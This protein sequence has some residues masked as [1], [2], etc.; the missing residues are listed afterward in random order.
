MT[1]RLS[2]RV[3]LTGVLLAL[4]FVMVA[5]EER[6]I[7]QILSEPNRYARR[8][9]GLRGTVVQSYSI[10]GRGAYQIE[11]GTGKLWV[12]S[13]RGVPRKGSRVAVKGRIEDG[14]DLGSLIKL[15]EAIGH[16][17]VLIDRGHRAEDRH[18]Y[19]D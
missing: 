15:P 16:G 14:F 18:G 4:S 8:E 9:V 12:I 3:A 10:L 17:V 13:D 5:C 19:R 2:P 1:K 7:H 11:D 6:T